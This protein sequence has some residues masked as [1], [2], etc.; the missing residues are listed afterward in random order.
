M[1]HQNVL[2]SVTNVLKYAHKVKMV[3]VGGKQF[4]VLHF[5]REIHIWLQLST[6]FLIPKTLNIFGLLDFRAEN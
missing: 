2:K 6:F 3:V 4:N 5:H 1:E